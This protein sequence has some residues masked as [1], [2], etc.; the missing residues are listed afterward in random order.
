VI[1]YLYSRETAAADIHRV[2]DMLAVP[3][4]LPNLA[5]QPWSLFTYMVLHESIWHI[6]FNMLWLYWFGKIFLQYL[7][8]RQLLMTYILGGLTGGLVYILAYNIFPVFGQELPNSYALGASASVMAIVTA[9]AFYVPNYTIYMLFIGR[10]R[11]VYLAIALFVFDFFMIPSGNAGG[12]IAH[13]GGALFGFTW[14]MLIYPAIRGKFRRTGRRTFGD[15]WK[16][17]RRKKYAETGGPD[18]ARPITDDEYNARRAENQKK[19]DEIL[20]KISRGGYESLTREEK[21]LLFRSSR[22]S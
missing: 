20:E 2:I 14:V 13:I 10:V 3:A 11:I 6:L 1:L 5:A 21:E 22:K 4:F 9:I 19:I 12:H 8:E 18:S 16:I 17:F 15:P 7:N